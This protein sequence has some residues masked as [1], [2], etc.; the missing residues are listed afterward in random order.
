VVEPPW[1]RVPVGPHAPIW[2]TVAAK[3]QVLAVVH[4]VTA[5]TRLLDVLAVFE[6]DP[7][8]Q[9]VFTWTR[10]SPFIDG[11]PAAIAAV[12]GVLVPWEQAVQLPFDLAISASQGGDLHELLAPLVI[13]GHGMG[14]N[15]YSPRKAKSEK[16]KAIRGGRGPRSDWARSSCCGTGSRSPRR[17]CSPTTNS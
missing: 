2:R 13:V 3:S 4:N 11:V 5:L 14:Y 12:G 1:V 7:R 15:K 17:L 16:R 9:V 10:S 6:A 8:I